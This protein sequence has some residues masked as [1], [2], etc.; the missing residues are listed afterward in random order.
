MLWYPRQILIKADVYLPQ[1]RQLISDRGLKDRD[2]HGLLLFLGSSP[3]RQ[4]LS[5]PL[6]TCELPQ[7]LLNQIKGT[8]VVS[9]P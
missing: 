4:V 1:Q 6:T 7:P 8:W 2:L 9:S 3:M 5:L